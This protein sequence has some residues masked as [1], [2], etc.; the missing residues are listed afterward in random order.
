MLPFVVLTTQRSGSTFFIRNLDSHTE[1]SCQGE[2]FLFVKR[3]FRFRAYLKPRS[4]FKRKFNLMNYKW[5]QNY[6]R[7]SKWR[8]IEYTFF[9][10]RL[11]EKFLSEIFYTNGNNKAIGFKLMYNQNN[12]IISN[13]LKKNNASIIHLIRFNLLKRLIS[14]TY[15]TEKK[16]AHS[17]KI[18]KPEKI[19][20]KTKNLIQKL[21]KMETEIKKNKKRFYSFSRYLEITYENFFS[22]RDVEQ[23]KILNFLGVDERS[24]LQCELK[25]INPNRIQDI[26]K[27]YEEVRFALRGTKFLGFLE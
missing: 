18:F 13:W 5:F 9:K 8:Q 22:N 15:M 2:L 24:F 1:V 11:T 17:T 25:K 27:N 21:T 6:L 4:G 3:D 19:R 20:L 26:L 10:K 14:Q 12:S 23:H 16:I 7:T